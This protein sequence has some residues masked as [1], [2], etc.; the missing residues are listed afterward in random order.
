MTYNKTAII[1]LDSVAFS[2]GHP[3]KILDSRGR[4]MR[5][6]DNSKFLYEDKTS[7]ELIASADKVMNNILSR[8]EFDS[9]IGFIKGY[10]TTLK[11]LSLDPGYKGNR[12]GESPE[13]WKPVK[14]DLIKRWNAVE[15]NYME[16]DDAVNITRLA[17]ENSHI[18]AID[19][20]LLLLEG[21]HYNWRENQW[22]TISKE[23]AKVH[24]WKDVIIGQSGD[25]IKGLPGVGK[26]NKIFTENIFEPNTEYV[27]KQFINKLGESDGIQEFYKN[28]HSLK[29]LEK[30]T[31]FVLPEIINSN[32]DDV[33][34][35]I[36]PEQ[37]EV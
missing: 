10:D 35:K 1:D 33:N 25:N 22:V 30:S 5:T 23:E 37:W 12:T 24:F 16:A 7:E 34:A 3:N 13:W 17:L 9:Y 18:V 36:A 29:I 27:L 26:N 11:R 8:G 14:K 19:K 2:I 20:D 32:N 15:I 6:E 31:D 28:Y 21:T 4:P